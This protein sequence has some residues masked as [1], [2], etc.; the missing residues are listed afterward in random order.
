VVIGTSEP[1]SAH[2]A[3]RLELE[4]AY[5]AASAFNR[6]CQ[7]TGLSSAELCRRLAPMIGKRNVL[8]RQTVAA[9][10]RGQQAVPLVAFLA[11]CDLAGLRPPMIF[12]L[13]AEESGQP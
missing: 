12:A 4:H 13:A 8:S 9:W 3:S 7:L 1:A 6:A 10:R 5:R 11:A 2:E